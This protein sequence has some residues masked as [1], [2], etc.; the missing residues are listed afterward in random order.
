MSVQSGERLQPKVGVA[1]DVQSI[2]AVPKRPEEFFLILPGTKATLAAS[3][4]D[5]VVVLDAGNSVSFAN[6][7]AAAVLGDPAPVTAREVSERIRFT[8][9]DALRFDGSAER[10]EARL[11]STGAWVEI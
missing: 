9:G 5:V 8:N 4:D 3:P 11:R 7:T 10:V 2:H 1:R 6:A